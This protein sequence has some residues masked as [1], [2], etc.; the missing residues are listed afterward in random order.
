[1]RVTGSLKM[2]EKVFLSMWLQL[3]QAYAEK[4]SSNPCRRSSKCRC[5]KVE[6]SMALSRN[7]RSPWLSVWERQ[8]MVGIDIRPW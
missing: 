5:L 4:G 6:T 7:M 8:T 1:M 2:V 3:S